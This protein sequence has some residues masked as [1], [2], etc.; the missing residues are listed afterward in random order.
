MREI[1]GMPKGVSGA[2]LAFPGV[3]G[4]LFHYDDFPVTYES[5]IIDVPQFDAHIEVYSAH[6]IV[7]VQ[8]DSPYVRGLPVTM[9]VREKV[10]E[11]GAQEKVVRKTYLDPY[12]AEFL[13]FYD[14]VIHGKTPKTSAADARNDIELY[15]MILGA[16]MERFE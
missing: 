4:V 7:R 10:G 3:L 5:G 13:D 16:D 6:K 8:W 12:T 9:T 11:A 1:I 15:K 14:C 2:V